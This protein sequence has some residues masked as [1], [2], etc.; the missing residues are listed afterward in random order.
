LEKSS[1]GEDLTE[2][3]VALALK[4]NQVEQVIGRKFLQL[5][6]KY[7]QQIID[8]EE[9]IGI[10]KEAI[11][12]L[13]YQ[14]NLRILITPLTDQNNEI[15]PLESTFD[16]VIF[17][18]IIVNAAENTL[19]AY[20]ART[21]SAETNPD[22]DKLFQIIF[23]QKDDKLICQMIDK[24]GGFPEKIIKEGFQDNVSIW[25]KAGSENITGNGI[26]LS[27]LKK[28]IEEHYP[29]SSLYPENI[30]D[31]NGIGACLTLEL[32]NNKL[33]QN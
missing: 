14:K 27:T 20:R 30:Y 6:N 26:G 2:S 7:P 24:A 23:S 33:N 18:E 31:E 22:Q 17:K 29:G 21:T 5:E 11:A 25:E 12:A 13:Y 4:A 3:A 9:L 1:L 28:I 8:Q 15:I 32:V 10:T 19:K 16:E